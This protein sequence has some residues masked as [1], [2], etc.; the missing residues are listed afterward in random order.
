MQNE[1]ERW[2]FTY[3]GCSKKRFYFNKK[4]F[5]NFPSPAL[6][7]FWINYLIFYS[8][9]LSKSTFSNSFPSSYFSY[10]L[11]RV[12]NWGRS[13]RWAAP[14]WPACWTGRQPNPSGT[15]RI[16]WASPDTSSPQATFISINSELRS[17]TWRRVNFECR[18]DYSNCIQ[19]LFYLRSA[20]FV[21]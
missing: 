9:T 1:K 14:S 21:D 18:H 5:V 12:Q 16:I 17:I 20:D 11:D 7:F 2:N 3:A 8:T 19:W 15:T 4:Y 10:A 6:G 13:K